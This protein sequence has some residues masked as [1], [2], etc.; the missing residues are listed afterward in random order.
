MH[1]GAQIQQQFDAAFPSN[2]FGKGPFRYINLITGGLVLVSAVLD[3][4]TFGDARFSN[5][6]L[7]YIAGLVIIACLML[8][9]DAEHP[10]IV[11]YFAFIDN[12][13]GRGVFNLAAGALVAQFPSPHELVHLLDTITTYV[14]LAVGAGYI[15]YGYT[16]TSGE[17]KFH[18]HHDDHGH[19]AGAHADVKADGKAGH[20][21][22]GVGVKVD[23][24]A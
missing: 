17:H 12:F 24:R 23:I 15:I 5:F 2:K 1:S 10:T 20:H 14:L 7:I 16:K 19:H 11:E 13:I 3:F 18:I 21:E 9:S 6:S 4:L 22:G 8:F